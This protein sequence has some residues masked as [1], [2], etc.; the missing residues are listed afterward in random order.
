MHPTF[1]KQLRVCWLKRMRIWLIVIDD[2]ST[3]TSVDYLR[4]VRD[5]RFT[6][7][8][9]ANAGAHNAINKGL[10]LAKGKYLQYSIPMTHFT[11]SV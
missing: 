3:D 6:L 9:Q 5:P 8:E 10:A 7:I 11:Q 1:D 2:G 4:T